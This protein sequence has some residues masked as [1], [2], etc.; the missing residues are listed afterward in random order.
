M[1]FPRLSILLL[2]VSTLWLGACANSYQKLLKSTDVNKKYEAAIKYY[3]KGDY[4][5]SGVL[6]EE[7]I[8]LLKGRPEAEKAQHEL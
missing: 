1:P 7:I 2:L 3:E 5:R 8:P 4:F 6:L